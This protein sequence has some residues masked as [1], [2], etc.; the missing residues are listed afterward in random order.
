MNFDVVVVAVSF[1]PFTLCSEMFHFWLHW[2]LVCVICSV[3][4]CLKVFPHFTYY[5]PVS[6]VCVE[7]WKSHTGKWGRKTYFFF[8]LLFLPHFVCFGI[9]FESSYLFCW[10]IEWPKVFYVYYLMWFFVVLLQY[11]TFTWIWN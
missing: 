3:H 4:E 7:R 1:T 9:Y 5:L 8:V 11:P 10:Y 6:I 2:K